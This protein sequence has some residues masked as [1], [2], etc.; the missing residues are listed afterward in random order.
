V[1]EESLEVREREDTSAVE[2]EAE[3]T[4]QERSSIL[5]TTSSS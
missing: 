5:A 2:A 4:L 1:E 3:K